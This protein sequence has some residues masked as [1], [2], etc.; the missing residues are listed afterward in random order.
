MVDKMLVSIANLA[1]RPDSW[2]YI[3]GIQKF[4]V[5]AEIFDYVVNLKLSGS[6]KLALRTCS[7]FQ[8]D[9]LFYL[10]VE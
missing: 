5:I 4:K 3:L 9:L 2:L 1:N 6:F 8:I 10:S 7:P